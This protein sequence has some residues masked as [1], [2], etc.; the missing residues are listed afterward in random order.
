M[1]VPGLMRLGDE[2]GG[3]GCAR[4]SS[5]AC[6]A[7]FDSFACFA[8]LGSLAAVCLVLANCSGSSSFGSLDPRYGVSSSARVVAPGEPIPKGG[9]YNRVGAAL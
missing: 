1:G 6:R 8:R 3:S 7:R 5:L 2:R 4:L 9:G